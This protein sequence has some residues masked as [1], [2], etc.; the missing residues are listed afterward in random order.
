MTGETDVSIDRLSRFE[1]SNGSTL[2]QLPRLTN[3]NTAYDTAFLIC[4]HSIEFPAFSGDTALLHQPPSKP[5]NHVS[6]LVLPSGVLT[7]FKMYVINS[8]K[9]PQNDISHRLSMGDFPP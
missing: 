6:K 9:K 8:N 1:K 3:T 4:D 5:T 7:G 2:A